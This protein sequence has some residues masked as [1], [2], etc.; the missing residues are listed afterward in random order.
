[1]FPC[2]SL[3]GVWSLV[4]LVVAGFLPSSSQSF[5][6]PVDDDGS[7]DALR[8][9]R[10]IKTAF[11]SVK[12]PR[13]K[14]YI[15]WKKNSFN[16]LYTAIKY[17]F[18]EISSNNIARQLVAADSALLDDTIHGPELMESHRIKRG[19]PK[20]AGFS[21]WA[22]KRASRGQSMGFSS[23]AGKRASG[24]DWKRAPFNSWAGKRSQGGDY[25]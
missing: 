13:Q 16:V 7:I 18:R 9:G 1:M 6:Q 24:W 8:W 15:K 21:S 12:I 3:L 25:Y 22:G 20:L 10:N 2:P 19:R 11:L 5:L 4:F 14:K 17:V 23:W